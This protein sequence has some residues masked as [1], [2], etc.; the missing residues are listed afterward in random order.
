MLLLCVVVGDLYICA[1]KLKCRFTAECLLWL[2]LR[3]FLV[4]VEWNASNSWHNVNL[5]K[6]QLVETV[7]NGMTL[8]LYPMID[9][10]PSL[11]C[12]PIRAFWWELLRWHRL[13]LLGLDDLNEFQFRKLI[14]AIFISLG[15]NIKWILFLSV[16]SKAPNASLEHIWLAIYGAENFS[17]CSTC[18]I[19]TKARTKDNNACRWTHKDKRA[20]FHH[21]IVFRHD[22][23]S[24]VDIDLCLNSN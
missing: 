3:R 15:E 8:L 16:R 12:F 20:S 4:F 14:F 10:M 17:S 7:K 2:A 22:L 24:M 5:S 13:L 19:I 18:F 21:R 1:L 6:K 23:S 11:L 9:S